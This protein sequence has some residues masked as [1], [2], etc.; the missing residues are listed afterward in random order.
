MNSALVSQLRDWLL[1]MQQ[2]N[3]KNP[4]KLKELQAQHKVLQQFI[5]E[6]HATQN[7]F[8]WIQDF[9][10]SEIRRQLKQKIDDLEQELK[11]RDTEI[12]EMQLRLEEMAMDVERSYNQDSYQ[13]GG[14]LSGAGPRAQIRPRMNNRDLG[15]EAVTTNRSSQ[16][17]QQYEYKLMIEREQETIALIQDLKEAL[18]ERE[19][20]LVDVK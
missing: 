7:I 15:E 19:A 2:F 3:L 4:N 14:G 13:S 6:E 11:G 9:K 18:K 5:L 17:Q 1:E 8:D 20:E 16:A 10:D 12:V